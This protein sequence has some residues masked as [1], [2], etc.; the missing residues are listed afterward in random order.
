MNRVIM[1][2]ELNLRKNKQTKQHG[3]ITQ[4]VH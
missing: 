3:N 4:S 2:N 1:K